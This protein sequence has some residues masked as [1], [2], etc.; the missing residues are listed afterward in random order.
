MA[1]DPTSTAATTQPALD[2]K[3]VE[4]QISATIAAALKPVTEALAGLPEMLKAAITPAKAAEDPGKQPPSATLTLADVA[5]LLE[6]RDAKRAG[7]AATAAKISA[8]VNAAVD[9][10]LKGVP[11]PYL[12]GLPQIEDAGKL[13]EAAKAIREQWQTDLKSAGVT[14]TNVGAQPGPGA[15][16]P[17]GAIDLSKLNPVQKIA[18][19]FTAA[20]PAQAA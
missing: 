17:A 1:N 2:L 5:K 19:M 11:K 13:A 4:T 3:A 16:T 10:H 12:A 14:A 6:E 18:T 9:A 15:T 8:A 7:D 20:K